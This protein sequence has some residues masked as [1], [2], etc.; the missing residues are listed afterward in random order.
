MRVLVVIE[1]VLAVQLV[2]VIKRSEPTSAAG[3][4]LRRQHLHRQPIVQPVSRR[5][6]PAGPRVHGNTPRPVLLAQPRT[7]HPTAIGRRRD[8]PSVRPP[9]PHRPPPQRLHLETALVHQ[10]MVIRAQLN[11]VLERRRSSSRP[12]LY[13]VRVHEPPVSAPGKRHPSSRLRNARRS[14]GGI[15]RVRRPTVNGRPSRSTIRTTPASHPSRLTVSGESVGPSARWQRSLTSS[16]ASVST[17]T[18]TTSSHRVRATGHRRRGRSTTSPAPPAHPPAAHPPAMPA[19]APRASP[20]LAAPPP[21][22]RN[23]FST[24]APSS[25]GSRDLESQRAV[26]LPVPPQVSL[27]RSPAVPPQASPTVRPRSRE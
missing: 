15:V 26:V 8:H 3:Q 12:V 16:A 6:R 11:E 24:T 19:S 20:R 5:Q 1:D 10:S 22:P 18:C 25:A 13:V 7:P 14:A 2:H 9:E 27:P 4:R 23:A 17:S 21:P